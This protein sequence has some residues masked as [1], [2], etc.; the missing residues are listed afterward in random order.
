MTTTRAE[1]RE[2]ERPC[3]DLNRDCWIQGPECWPLH[4]KATGDSSGVSSHW[5]RLGTDAKLW[6][7]Q[8]AHAGNRA[9]GT[10]MEGLYVTTTLRVPWYMLATT[11]REKT[12]TPQGKRPVCD[13]VI[14]YTW[15]G[16]NW[17]PSACGADVIATRPQV[18]CLSGRWNDL[19]S[20]RHAAPFS[21]LPYFA[22]A[23]CKTGVARLDMHLWSSG[24]DVSPTR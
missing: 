17:R 22:Q 1:R 3:A 2:K 9:R 20:T 11:R 21:R 14:R 8:I 5:P 24:Y 6:C 23:S 12:R 16:S 10:S 4:H 7:Q 15:P 18:R 19:V 13:N